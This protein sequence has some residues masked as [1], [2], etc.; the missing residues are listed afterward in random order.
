MSKISEILLNQRVRNRIIEVLEIY[1]SFENQEIFGPDEIIN[2]WDDL[3]HDNY[4][5]TLVEPVFSLEEQY[6][7]SDFHNNWKEICDNTPQYMP[8][9]S[10]LKKDHKWISLMINAKKALNIFL[11]RGRFNEEVEIF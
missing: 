10:I 4:L 11:I 6:V 5:N 2:M 9:L 1:C 7:F 8:P 3:V